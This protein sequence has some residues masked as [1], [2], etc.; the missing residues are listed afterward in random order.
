MYKQ[1]KWSIYIM[2]GDT[3]AYLRKEMTTQEAI[4]WLDDN[5]DVKETNWFMH[6]IGTQV[7]CESK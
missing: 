2:C 1:K 7:F 5:C 6:G 3:K 4:K